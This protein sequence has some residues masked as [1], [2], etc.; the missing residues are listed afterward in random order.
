MMSLTVRC[1]SSCAVWALAILGS[2]ALAGEFD[3]V[4]YELLEG[5][6]LIDDCFCDRIPIEVPLTG[7]MVL[8]RKPVR[9]VGELYSVS[10]IDFKASGPIGEYSVLGGGSY[11]RRSPE[12]TT[13]TLDL[14]INLEGGISLTTDFVPGGVPWPQVDISI[15][16]DGSRDPNHIYR[17]RL[18][19]APRDRAVPY[20][21]VP[22]NLED[23]SGSFLIDDCFCGRLTRPLP[24]EG[25]FTL[26]PRDAGGPNPFNTYDVLSFFCR[27]LDPA[28]ELTVVG[29]GEYV[30]GGEVAV[31][32][33]MTLS[34]ELPEGKA[35]E[36]AAE[37]GPFPEG[38]QFPQINVE[39]TEVRPEGEPVVQFYR[40]SLI[41]VPTE[42]EPPPDGP[43]FRRGDANEDAVIDISDAVSTLLWL[44][45]GADGPACADA[46]DANADLTHDLTDPIFTLSYLFGSGAAPP[47]PGPTECGAGKETIGCESYAPCADK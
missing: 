21:I 44:F 19:A 6:M 20:T 11:Y 9:I 23:S 25:T 8:T 2:P 13:M 4:R 22:G 18:V 29:S 36:M 37:P 46:A 38:V 24:I 12:E 45:A 47:A 5:S 42:D 32:Q 16:E 43:Q 40:L 3:P 35:V 10:G 41:A 34:L 15:G 39:L 1:V 7:T 26:F 17:L 27:V 30:W 28:A 14:E 31:T 33:A